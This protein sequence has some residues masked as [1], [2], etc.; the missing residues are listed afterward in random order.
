MVGS[1]VERW[2]LCMTLYAAVRMTPSEQI[3]QRHPQ[4]RKVGA[5]PR[6]VESAG[7]K[8]LRMQNN[9]ANPPRGTR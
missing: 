5:G 4:S 3:D 2:E 1:I 7:E 8:M 6:L 9:G